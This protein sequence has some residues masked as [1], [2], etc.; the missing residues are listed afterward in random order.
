MRIAKA[1]DIIGG[2]NA[3]QNRR[4]ESYQSQ[5]STDKDKR[6][7]DPNVLNVL[8]EF[9]LESFNMQSVLDYL[10]RLGYARNLYKYDQ[11]QDQLRNFAG[12]NHPNFSWNR[13]FKKAK[14][15]LIDEVRK[16][17]LKSLKYHGNKDC[18]AC[19]P[20]KK[21]H[22]GF[23]FIL[24]GQR[25]KES[26][27]ENI[28]EDF[29]KE[30]K[31]ARIHGSFNKP[32]MCMVRTSGL[33]P[34]EDGKRT[35]E[36]EI[37]DRVVSA[38]DLFQV[39]AECKF[40][41]P[42]QL[43]MSQA[44]WYAGGKDDWEVSNSL[45]SKL[46]SYGNSLT[47]DYSKFDQHISDWLIREAF[48]VVRAAFNTH[49]FDEELFVVIRE[50]FIHKVFI[51]GDGQLVESHKGVPSGSMFTQI[52]DSV[53]N[54]LMVDCFMFAKGVYKWKMVIMGD[55]NIIFTKDKIIDKEI[56]GYLSQ[57]FGVK[58]SWGKSSHAE[59]GVNHP[60]FLSRTWTPFGVWRDPNE[61]FARILF[62]ERFRDYQ[63]TNL[64][65]AQVVHAYILTFPLG[66]RELID[67]PGFEA[68]YGPEI[69]RLRNGQSEWMSGLMRFRVEYLSR[70]KLALPSV[71]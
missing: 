37:K 32:I 46:N 31:Q 39:L 34:F 53:V 12:D 25:T 57:N 17:N 58:V 26:Y 2:L 54:K 6:L 44:E 71:A 68:Y 28:F 65:P 11:I 1:Y 47:V 16:W 9:S 45:T 60:E 19:I 50:D 59:R 38:V 52:I 66:M 15:A 35:D 13:N 23:S 33:T 27:F 10:N 20:K 63:G 48:D 36:F 4:L 62:P 29:S 67:V 22:A 42:F 70:D 64:H 49:W 55:D 7:F 51:D 8:N 56:A 41:K 61:L 69:N 40:A 14:S 18:I 43:R 21:A 24:T 30:E 5:L 3:T